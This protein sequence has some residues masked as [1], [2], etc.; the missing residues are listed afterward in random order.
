MWTSS[1]SIDIILQDRASSVTFPL[2]VGR[3]GGKF[4]SCTSNGGIAV[5]QGPKDSNT[6]LRIGSDRG[7]LY[8]ALKGG[9]S[10]ITTGLGPAESALATSLVKHAFAAR[11]ARSMST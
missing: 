6:E 11:V 5:L 10:S 2:F 4:L 8:F 7:V 3:D 1:G 9:D